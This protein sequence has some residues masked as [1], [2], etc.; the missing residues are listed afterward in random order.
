MNT[1]TKAGDLH[2]LHDASSCLSSQSITSETLHAVIDTPSF[3]GA[4]K[5]P[6]LTLR[7]RV[8][9]EKGKTFEVNSRCL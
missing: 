8:V 6:D 2:L 7:Q 4:G 3:I 5:S 9:E 1:C